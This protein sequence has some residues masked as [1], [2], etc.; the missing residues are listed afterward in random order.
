M[1]NIFDGTALDLYNANGL[2]LQSRWYAVGAWWN[3]RLFQK[4]T[5]G[6]ISPFATGTYRDGTPFA[7]LNFASQEYLNLASHPEVVEAAIYA[8]KH[9]G[10]HSAGSATLMGN[11]ELSVHLERRLAGYLGYDDGYDDCLVFPI[12]WAAGYGAV[13]TLVRKHAIS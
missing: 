2:D 9:Y 6:R 8:L 3:G 13:K 7:G 4:V 10:C 11:T 5:S 1:S 12:G